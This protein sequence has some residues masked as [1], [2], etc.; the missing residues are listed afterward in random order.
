MAI[1]MKMGDENIKRVICF[2]LI[3]AICFCTSCGKLKSNSGEV[4]KAIE[5]CF[6]GELPSCSTVYRMSASCYS[7]E[8]LTPQ[9]ASLLYYGEKRDELY[10]LSLLSDYTVRLA[11]GQSGAEIHIL[12]VRAMS[13]MDTIE[14]MLIKRLDYI[15]SRSLYIYSPEDY[16]IYASSA[17]VYRVGDYVLLLATPDNERAIEAVKKLS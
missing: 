2:I 16:E 15:K 1:T 11:D 3:F 7:R 10:E 13:D 12:R 9:L 5:S 6:A 8:Y 14:K 17:A 4:L